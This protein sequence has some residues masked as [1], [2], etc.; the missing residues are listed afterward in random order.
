MKTKITAIVCRCIKETD[1]NS[2]SVPVQK[3]QNEKASI[4][5]QIQRIL[6]DHP[7]KL[8]ADISLKMQDNV[9]LQGHRLIFASKASFIL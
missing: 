3:G 6:P 9:V 7:E 8:F 5:A 2:E 1:S 4:G